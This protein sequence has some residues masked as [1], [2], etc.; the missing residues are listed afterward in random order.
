MA[1][2]NSGKDSLRANNLRCLR[3]LLERVRAE[4]SPYADSK[5]LAKC[6]IMRTELDLQCDWK[7]TEPQYFQP[8]SILEVSQI[9]DAERE[10]CGGCEPEFNDYIEPPMYHSSPADGENWEDLVEISDVTWSGQLLGYMNRWIAQYAYKE[11]TGWTR[12]Q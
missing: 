5:F 7:N 1:T 12:F 10:R 3:N 2:S 9:I 8:A 4:N 6:S 11:K